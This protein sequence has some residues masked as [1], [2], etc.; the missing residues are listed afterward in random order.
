MGFSKPVDLPEHGESGLVSV[1]IFEILK[2]HLVAQWLDLGLRPIPSLTTVKIWLS[3][4]SSSID[5][6]Y[7][8][9][10]GQGKVSRSECIVII[11]YRVEVNS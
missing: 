8:A 1:R 10:N 7:L 11:L 5:S 2:V 6:W 9:Q 3:F 4:P